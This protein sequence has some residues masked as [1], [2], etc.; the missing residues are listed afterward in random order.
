M[1]VLD[2]AADGDTA[3]TGAR[4]GG[5]QSV[6]RS[7]VL[8]ELI[9]DA[10]GR[11]TLS[12]LAA[13]SGLPAPTIHRLVR[14][15]L[16][17]GYVRQEASR[18]YALGPALVRLGEGAGR[19]LGAW[20]QPVLTALVEATGET[21]NMAMLDGDRVVYLAQVPSKHS[22][23]MFTEVGRRVHVHCTAVGKALAAQLPEAEVRALLARAG[24]PAQTSNT[25]TEPETLITHL[26]GVRGQ[27]YATDE[28][29]QE[30]GVRC[31]AVPVLDAPAR[32]ALSV[33]GPDARFTPEV[34]DRVVPVMLRAAEELARALRA[35]A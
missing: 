17:G 27:G 10:G 24:M 26:A 21:S 3:G 2:G 23:R 1:T 31:V 19:L 22:M 35:R 34:R 33:S 9:A 6:E 18:A 4:A 30:L 32:V 8:L 20:V 25:L 7:F 11:A 16:D 12:E 14:T 13:R 28:G 29:E 15:L 5:V